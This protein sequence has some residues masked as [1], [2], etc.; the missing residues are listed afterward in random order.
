MQIIR[1]SRENVEGLGQRIRSAR[2][3]SCRPV[4]ALAKD[5]GISHSFWLNC[6]KERKSIR[7]ETLRKMEQVLGVVL[8][9]DQDDG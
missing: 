7:L 8:Y 2:L 3:A 1:E 6:E 9:E 4:R 5:I